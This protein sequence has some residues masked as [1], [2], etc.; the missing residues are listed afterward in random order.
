MFA[1]KPEEPDYVTIVAGGVTDPDDNGGILNK[2]LLYDYC[3]PCP[4]KCPNNL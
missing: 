2:N 3:E 1:A 4:N